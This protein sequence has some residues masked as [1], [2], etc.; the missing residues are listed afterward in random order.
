[1]SRPSPIPFLFERDFNGGKKVV[2]PEEEAVPAE[3]HRAE[4]A[5]AEERGLARGRAEGRREALDSEA[6]RLAETMERLC[7]ALAGELA[8]TEERALANE[9][10]AIELALVLARKVAGKALEE[11]PHAAIEAAAHQCF[12]EARTAPHVVVRVNEALVEVVRE[13]L[14]PL[15]AEHGFAGKLV[16]MGEPDIALP[17]SRFEWADGG[18]VR[19][20]ALIEQ[21]I[22][23][24]VRIHIL[25]SRDDNGEAP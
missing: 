4:L 1:M 19:D 15:V 11:F 14:K 10:A 17:D 6:R 5:E 9:A 23:D 12:R 20:S 24:A 2:S 22:S 13:R 18:I 16:V 8:R 7:V 21:A 3:R 25:T